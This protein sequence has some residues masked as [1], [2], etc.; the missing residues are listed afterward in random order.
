MISKSYKNPILLFIGATA[1]QAA[2]CG[3]WAAAAGVGGEVAYVA[4]Q[5]KRSTGETIDDQLIVASIKT[6]LL[7]DPLVSGL[8]INVDSYKGVVDLIG[9]VSSYT[10]LARAIEVAQS[11]S[12]VKEVR[13]KL[14]VKNTH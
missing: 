1:I 14:N 12:G 13:T 11:V 8:Q 5:E 6:K 4:S 10:E 7:A 2:L 9:N 3:C